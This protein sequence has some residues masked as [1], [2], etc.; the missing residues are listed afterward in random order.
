MVMDEK[1][2]WKPSDL[3][4]KMMDAVGHFV[5]IKMKDGHEVIGWACYYED[6]TAADEAF[7]ILYISNE[8]GDGAEGYSG[9]DI[10]D[11]KLSD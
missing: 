4:V 6:A 10:I 9:E 3:D 5:K 2:I 8:N 11:I 1:Y 7:P